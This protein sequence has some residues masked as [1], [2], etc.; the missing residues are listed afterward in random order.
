MSK[1]KHIL[2]DNY[3]EEIS[4]LGITT[5]E[6]ILSLILEINSLQD[7]TFIIEKSVQSPKSAFSFPHAISFLD[8]STKLR[9]IK[10]KHEGQFLFPSVKTFDYIIVCTGEIAEKTT[11]ELSKKL[12]FLKNIPLVVPVEIKKL[13]KLKEIL[14]SQ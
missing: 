5:S 3:S 1:K 9:L 6:S 7:Y 2:I 10:I 4:A 14:K 8:E 11:S 12:K 13:T